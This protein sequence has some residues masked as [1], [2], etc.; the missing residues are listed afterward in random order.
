MK[1]RCAVII[2]LGLAGAVPV[3]CGGD[4]ATTVTG[5]STVVIEVDPVGNDFAYKTE[6]VR[7]KAGD[8]KVVLKNPQQGFE[9]DVRIEDTDGEQLGGTKTITEGSTSVLLRDLEP[10]EY[11][12][13]SSTPGYRT[14]GME[15][16]LTVE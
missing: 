11:V 15:G 12:F 3:A 13:Y 16:T 4:G 1:K 6:A 5:K 7:A 8:V 2:L 9:H 14:A 10:G